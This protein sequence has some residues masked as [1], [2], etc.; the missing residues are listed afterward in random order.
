LTLH[1]QGFPVLFF[2]LIFAQH[3]IQYAV[4]IVTV[5]GGQGKNIPQFFD[6]PWINAGKVGIGCFFITPALEQ[7]ERLYNTNRG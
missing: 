7:V 3:F 1:L 5:F 6:A 4:Q 2:K